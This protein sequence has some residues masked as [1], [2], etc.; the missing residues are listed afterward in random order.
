MLS[1]S[2][3][4]LLQKVRMTHRNANILYKSKG[5]QLKK[6]SAFVFQNWSNPNAYYYKGD[7]MCG[8]LLLMLCSTPKGRVITSTTCTYSPVL[9]EIQESRVVIKLNN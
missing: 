7:T 6:L 4:P 5:I 1:N 9:C 2:Q 8:R 3:F